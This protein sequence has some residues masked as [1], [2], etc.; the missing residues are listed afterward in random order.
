METNSSNS[1]IRSKAPFAIIIVIAV[2]V[3]VCQCLSPQSLHAAIEIVCLESDG[4]TT[5]NAGASWDET[6]KGTKYSC[7]CTSNGSSCSPSSITSKSGGPSY[8]LKNDIKMQ[9]MQG[10][11]QSAIDSLFAVPVNRR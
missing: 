4:K 9:I 7:Q 8:N 1:E 6:Y 5:H 10:V 2:T 3:V 11:L